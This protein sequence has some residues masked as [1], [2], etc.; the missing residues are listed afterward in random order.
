MAA[1]RH[2]RSRRR[3]GRRTGRCA[4]GPT[5]SRATSLLLCSDGLTDMLDD[6]QIAAI[7]AAEG[8]PEEACQRLVEEANAAGGRDNI[9][10]I[11]ARF[12]TI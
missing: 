3:H 9:T 7:L 2:Q 4:E 10:C 5:W 6:E 12:E 8:E 11:V 1:R